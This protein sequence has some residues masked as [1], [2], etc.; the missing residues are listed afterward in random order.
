MDP[1]QSNND[2]DD[3]VQEDDD[4]DDNNDI[5]DN[6]SD[7][8][9]R[10]EENVVYNAHD[11]EEEDPQN[12]TALPHPL[13]PP[14]RS[15][16][17]T[18]HHTGTTTTTTT[19]QGSIKPGNWTLGSKI[20]A[21]AFGVVHIGMNTLTGTLMA[22]KTIQ[23]HHHEN[24]SNDDTT[25]ILRD[26]QRE[27]DLLKSLRHPNIVRYLGSEMHNHE[28]HIFQEWVPGGS[29]TGMLSKFGPFSVPVIRS[30]I[31]Q[32]LQGLAYLHDNHI[33][34]RDIKG[35]NLLVNDE[36]CV[37]L[38]DFGASRKIKGKQHELDSSL[39]MR[40]TPYFMAPEVFEER[41][42]SKA[43]IWSIGCVIVQ[44]YTGSPPFKNMGFSNI[45]TLYKHIRQLES[46]PSLSRK[47]GYGQ[48]CPTA[49]KEALGRVVDA[50]FCLE[51]E[52][53]PSASELQSSEFFLCD[54]SEEQATMCNDDPSSP[55]SNFSWEML[56]SPQVVANMRSRRSPFASPPVLLASPPLPKVTAHSPSIQPPTTS[57]TSL[58]S[59]PVL[60][61]S[62]PPD[63]RNWPG[64]AKEEHS[65][66]QAA[67]V[68]TPKLMK[69]VQAHGHRETF[70]SSSP[71]SLAYSED[72]TNQGSVLMGLDLLSTSSVRE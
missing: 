19:T 8:V 39:T 27:I 70:K 25:T 66:N 71:A 48:D 46:P 56:Q 42:G 20:G 52:K 35:S 31:S 26:V 67:S 18:T 55:A 7:T 37:K 28:L 72:S 2:N 54:P 62:P 38:A 22:V 21:G 1:Q 9:G 51:P 34:H 33:I 23:I 10:V 57:T 15:I 47:Q 69:P 59:S 4:D 17:T 64:W 53:R 32:T 63:T 68:H 43:D 14:V 6:D 65:K 13:S 24:N 61:F 44:M 58:S 12:Q 5:D 40:G 3:T 29:V 36:G 16:V 50:C 49:W 30:Y 45:I 41:Y 11:L 60:P